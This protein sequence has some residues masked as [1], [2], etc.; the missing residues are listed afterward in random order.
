MKILLVGA[1]SYVGAR[2][3]F[4]LKSTFIVIGTYATHQLSKDFLQLDITDKDAVG[5]IIKEQNPD[6]ILHAANNASS[7]WCEANPEKAVELNQTATQYIMDTANKNNI[8]VIYISTVYDTSWKFQPT[9]IKHISDVICACIENNRWNKAISISV[10]ELKSR[11][12][13]A[14]DILTPFG[15]KVEPIDNHDDTFAI[16]KDELVELHKHNLPQYTYKQMVEQIVQEI[17]ER[18]KFKL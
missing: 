1:N 6:I 13:T 15:I 18:D 9:Y 12:D 11:F 17:K 3:Y 4:D 8:K 14:Y 10:P 5:T 2:L 7:K 16:F